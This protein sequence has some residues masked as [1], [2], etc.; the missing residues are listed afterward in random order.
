MQCAEFELIPR[1]KS[2]FFRMLN[3][4]YTMK[5]TEIKAKSLA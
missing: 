1:R 3:S 4:S 5:L 2:D